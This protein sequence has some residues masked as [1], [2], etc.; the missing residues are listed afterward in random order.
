MEN[1]YK[2]VVSYI[3]DLS[4]EIPSPETLITIRNTIPQYLMKVDIKSKPLKRKLIEV[5][6]TLTYENPKLKKDKGF[7]QIKYATAIEIKDVQIK[8]TELEKIILCDLQVEIYP[9]LE[10]ALLNLLHD[11]G[12]PN[13]KFDKKVDFENLYNQRFN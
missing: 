10:K 3:Q 5:L 11:S 8:K 12:Y 7:F 4:V 2:I 1:K 13:I 9:K 6:T